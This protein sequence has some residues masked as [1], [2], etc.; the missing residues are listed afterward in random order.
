MLAGLVGTLM[1]LFKHLY[2]MRAAQGPIAHLIRAIWD[3]PYI[4]WLWEHASLVRPGDPS[5]AWSVYFYV[6][7]GLTLTGAVFFALVGRLSH[8]IRQSNQE[9]RVEHL[10]RERLG[11]TYSLGSRITTV[12][13]STFQGSVLGDVTGPYAQV[14]YTSS[15]DLAAISALVTETLARI[16][17]FPLTPFQRVQFK[18]H[19]ETIRQECASPT[20]N[21]TLLRRALVIR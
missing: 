18:T 17:D 11:D 10:K 6:C 5:G 15:N 19:L 1:A 21:H 12:T 14:H 8:Y 3:V 7:L 13:N 4:P 16:G 2:A 9:A 20:P